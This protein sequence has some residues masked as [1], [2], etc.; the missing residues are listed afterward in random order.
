MAQEADEEEERGKQL[1]AAGILVTASVCT[2]WTANAIPAMP[3]TMRDLHS[4]R[5][6]AK[7]STETAELIA[8]LTAVN[9]YVERP[10]TA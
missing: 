5:T 8:T 10:C 7:S 2:G 4:V 3:A 9:P 6:N 1:R